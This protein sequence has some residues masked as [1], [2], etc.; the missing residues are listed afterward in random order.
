ML[1]SAQATAFVLFLSIHHIVYLLMFKG[2]GVHVSPITSPLFRSVCT[3]GEMPNTRKLLCIY[4]NLWSEA[5]RQIFALFE[6][7]HLVSCMEAKSVQA[8]ERTSPPGNVFKRAWLCTH[9][10]VE[11]GHLRCT[12]RHGQIL[13]NTMVQLK[14]RP[15]E[16]NRCLFRLLRWKIWKFIWP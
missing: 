8:T 2:H 12:G 16:T 10:Y 3:A 9:I 4:A 5:N 13:V 6:N 15:F 1:V 7:V 14:M 11:L